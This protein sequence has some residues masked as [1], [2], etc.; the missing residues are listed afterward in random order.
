MVKIRNLGTI[1]AIVLIASLVAV[2]GFRHVTGLL[3]LS[4]LAGFILILFFVDPLY[5]YCFLVSLYWYPKILNYL[6]LRDVLLAGYIGEVFL[7][8]FLFILFF[9]WLLKRQTNRIAG[10]LKTPGLFP[11][12]IFSLGTF[13]SF[14]FAQSPDRDYA[15]ILFRKNCLYGPILY[16]ATVNLIRN[17]KDAEKLAIV[18]IIGNCILSLFLFYNFYFGSGFL[19]SVFEERLGGYFWVGGNIVVITCIMIGGQISTIFP[20]SFAFYYLSESKF[21]KF[22][23][24]ASIFC[25]TF[26]LVNTLTRSA[27]VDSALSV[28]L[29][30]FLALKYSIPKQLI[31]LFR[32]NV[33]LIAVLLAVA[34]GITSALHINPAVLSRFL[35]LRYAV[36]DDS[37]LTR[38]Y[39]WGLSFKA[40]LG[41][42]MGF[43]F[44]ETYP[45]GVTARYPHSLY[46]GTLLS[47]GL[48]GTIGYFYFIFSIIKK[49][50]HSLKIT[51]ENRNKTLLIATLSSIFAFLFFGIFEHQGFA[52][53][54]YISIWVIFGI[55]AAV[56]SNSIQKEEGV[57]LPLNEK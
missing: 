9:I 10:I 50:L 13:I 14:Y 30:I 47:S 1:I 18:L 37:L 17:I 2:F 24:L 4:G 5:I 46:V 23:G 38:I 51:N 8:I 27:W 33:Y 28:I 31:G 56:S 11:L 35:N 25:L 34:I 42:P 53:D 19:G 20:I 6:F 3:F 43:G 16:I 57:E 7:Y 12:L 55:S 44:M 29:V 52:P 36:E 48:F 45:L 21:F 54:I 41:N 32:K 40:F 39:I 15:Y 26:P 22:V 49:N